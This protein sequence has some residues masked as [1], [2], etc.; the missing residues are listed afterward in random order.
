M[1]LLHAPLPRFKNNTKY[2]RLS[3]GP[4]TR[5]QDPVLPST[6]GIMTLLVAARWALLRSLNTRLWDAPAGGKPQMW[7]PQ[8]STADRFSHPDIVR[9]I[10]QRWTS[11]CVAGSEPTPKG[12]TGPNHKNH[13]SSGTS[14]S[15]C[16]HARTGGAQ[17]VLD[18]TLYHHSAAFNATFILPEPIRSHRAFRWSEPMHVCLKA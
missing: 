4:M 17:R 3:S 18:L 11:A 15:R 8:N 12:I 13:N 6:V 9:P 5:P 1:L 2:I 7:L 10:R 16:T 14:F